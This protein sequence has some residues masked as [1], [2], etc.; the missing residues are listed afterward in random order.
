MSIPFLAAY[1]SDDEKKRDP[2]TEKTTETPIKDEELESPFGVT[3]KQPPEPSISTTIKKNPPKRRNTRKKKPGFVLPKPKLDDD[4][5][6]PTTGIVTMP[7]LT[8]LS[9]NEHIKNETKD[10]G[11]NGID[12]N[13]KVRITDLRPPQ[14][15]GSKNV[16]TEDLEKYYTNQHLKEKSARENKKVNKTDTEN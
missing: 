14:M 10:M 8:K 3:V 15:R 7:K 11:N 12:T 2:V 9:D 13:T 4:Q 1:N 5:P 6:L 16:S